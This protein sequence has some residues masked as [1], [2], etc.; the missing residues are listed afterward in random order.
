MIPPLVQQNI[1][2]SFLF[3]GDTVHVKLIDLL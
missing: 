1:I 3:G 2:Q